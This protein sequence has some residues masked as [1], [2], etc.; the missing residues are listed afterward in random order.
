MGRAVCLKVAQMGIPVLINY[1]SNE[2]AA[3][4]AKALVEAEGVP[5]EVVRVEVRVRHEGDEA[6]T[7][8]GEAPPED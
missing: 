4:E 6:L 3:R 8:W 2:A 1:Q 5:A 7:R